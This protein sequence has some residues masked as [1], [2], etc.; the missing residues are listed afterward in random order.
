MRLFACFV[1]SAV[2]LSSLS[3]WA[4][5]KFV[6]LFD[7]KTLEG[8][9]GDPELWHV[10]DG[11]IVGSTEKKTLKANS[12][13]ATKKSYKNFVLK[14]KFKLRNHNSG[15]QFRSQ[16]LKDYRVVGYQ[17]DIADNNYMGILYEEG[18]TR[19][20][21]ANVTPE[22]T[23][24]VTPEEVA[25]HVK[26]GDWNEY[27][28]RADGPHITLAINGFTTVDYTETSDKAETEGIIALQ[29]HAGP[30]MQVEF[31]AIEIAELP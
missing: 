19:N 23:A 14:A 6:P 29:L 30:P 2:C 9:E 4:E 26:K 16:L 25:K 20:I 27:V 24:K 28:I 12:F 15:I 10:Q 31:K 3:A 7:G 11:T 18:L 22:F 21:L 1:A 13:L 5:E 17:A 8:W